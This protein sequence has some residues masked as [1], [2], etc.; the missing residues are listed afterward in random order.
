[1]DADVRAY[2]TLAALL[3]EQFTAALGHDGAR[4]EALAKDITALVD[5]LEKRR[6]ARVALVGQLLPQHPP[7][8]RCC[9]R[10]RAT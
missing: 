2:R 4:L 5:T 10:L 6:Q 9:P 3:E 7:C 8:S 1:M